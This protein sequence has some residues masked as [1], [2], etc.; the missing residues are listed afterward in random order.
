MSRDRLLVVVLA[1]MALFAL[2]AGAAS[3]SDPVVVGGGEGDDRWA[4]P[5]PNSDGDVGI[6]LPLDENASPIAAAD[7]TAC[8]SPLDADLGLLV[9]IALVA[10]L[11]GLMWRAASAVAA[12]ATAIGLAPVGLLVYG[13]LTLGCFEVSGDNQSMDPGVPGN[14]AQPPEGGA[15]GQVT[16]QLVELSTEPLI[17]LIGLALVGVLAATVA[18]RGVGDDGGAGP[19]V[20]E[21]DGSP[22]SATELANIAGSTADRLA[23]NPGS[24]TDLENEVYRAW[25]E[26]TDHLEVASPA[27]STPGEFAAAA[28]ESGLDPDDVSALTRLFEEVRYGD[29]SVTPEREQRAIETLRHIERH[30]GGDGP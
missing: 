9:V 20:S 1:A 24:E 28:I 16:E 7:G 22:E 12:V 5:D 11:A 23:A 29:R 26:M 30:Y 21:D 13:L 2:A 27:A 19:K 6:D 10:V 8:L 15:P 17:I 14:G 3:L 25:R 18:M 4:E